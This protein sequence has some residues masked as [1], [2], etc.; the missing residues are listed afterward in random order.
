MRDKVTSKQ[1]MFAAA[2]FIIATS[3]VT[4]PL[5]TFSKNNSWIAVIAGFTLAALI[6]LI[7]AALAWRF[8]G[9]TLIEINDEV[10]GPVAGKLASALYIFF[11]FTLACF[12]TNIITGFVKAFVLQ[13]TPMTMLLLLFVAVCIWAA[14]KGPVKLMMYSTLLV[15]VSIV[16]VVMNSLLLYQSIDFRNLLPVFDLPFTDY[17]VGT[18][19]VT[20]IPFCDPF[21]LI[22]LLPEMYKP[23]EFGKAMTKGLCI[24]AAFLL[25]IVLRDISVMGP[26]TAIHT[27]PSFST[28]RQIDVGDIITRMD[29]IYISILIALMFYKVAALFYASVSGFQRLLK[30]ESNQF[31]IYIFG[32]LLFLYSLTVFRS[33]SEHLEWLIN[34]AAEI[35]QTFFTICLPL[36]TLL[37]AAFR[38][39][40]KNGSPASGGERA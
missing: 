30:L 38:G 13:N 37:V 2:E 22:M 20:V 39:L 28:I 36:A 23:R 19:A 5:Y 4:K 21:A 14:R 3:L 6:Y 12:D 16:L 15:Y 34:G 10:L 27:F 1:I 11:F 17:L 32:A 40:Y 8:P 7:Y 18:H 29:I 35:F 24:G 25:F 26:M 31:L 9:C 33:S